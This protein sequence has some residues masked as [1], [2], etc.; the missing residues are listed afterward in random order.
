MNV[1]LV[2]AHP[3][4]ASFVGAMLDTAVSTLT[5]AGH[6]VG[7]SDLY[8][9]GFDAAASDR[10]F[11]ARANADYLNIG[12]EQAHAARHGGF[13]PD[14]QREMDRLAAADLVI[15]MFPMWWF[16]VPAIL[17]GW[18][19]RVLAYGVAYDFERTWNNGV[20]QGK[21][22]ML[23]FTTGAPADVFEPDGRS[24]DLERV[25]WPLHGGVL[26]LCGFEVLRPYTAWAVPWIGDD[27]RAAVLDDWK[28]RLAGLADEAPLFFHDLEDFGENRRLRPDVEPGTPAQHRG[29][30]KHLGPSRDSS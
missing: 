15:F 14:L 7:V 13:A 1:L 29:P 10:D 22:A 5:E 16:S 4:R 18:M 30:R 2:F 11:T 12:A 9:D 28:S 8:A 17:K 6:T 26:A 19:D 21:R 20:Y 24:G 3:E 27:G 23:A 25:L